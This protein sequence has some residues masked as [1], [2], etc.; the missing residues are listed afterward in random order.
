MTNCCRPRELKFSPDGNDGE[1][2]AHKGD[3]SL[4]IQGP[5]VSLPHTPTHDLPSHEQTDKMG[6]LAPSLLVRVGEVVAPTERLALYKVENPCAAVQ[7]GVEGVTRGLLREPVIPEFVE[8][9]LK[10]GHG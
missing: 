8:A 10:R 4:H 9:G 3:T 7:T 6:S 1:G 5:I 2:V